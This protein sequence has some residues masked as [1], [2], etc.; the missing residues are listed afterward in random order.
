MTELCSVNAGTPV[1]HTDTR[2]NGNQSELNVSVSLCMFPSL[3]KSHHLGGNST[4][5]STEYWRPLRAETNFKD[6][7][8]PLLNCL[9]VLDQ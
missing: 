5:Y 2:H 7:L 3:I 4:Q 9:T 6:N 8:V 1:S